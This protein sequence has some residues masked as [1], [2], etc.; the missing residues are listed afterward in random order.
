MENALPFFF[1]IVVL[2][3]IVYVV[4][5]NYFYKPAP[6]PPVPPVPPTPP[7]FPPL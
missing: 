5:K 3:G 2:G 6:K 7:K 4:Y 1:V